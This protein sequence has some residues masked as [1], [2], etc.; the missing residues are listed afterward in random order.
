[1][2]LPNSGG[3]AGARVTLTSA[4]IDQLTSAAELLLSPL[5][6]ESVDAWRSSV[7]RALKALLHADSAGFLLPV[8][9][10]LMLYSDEHDPAEL[11]RY[12]D[13]PPPPLIDGTPLWEQ[14]IKS[15]VI[16]L[17][18]AYGRN[19]GLYTDSVYYQEYAG[20]NGAHDTLAAAVTVGGVDARG[21]ACMHFWHERPDGRLFS[22][23]E[24]ALLRLLYPA[25]KA[26]AETQVAWGTQRNDLLNTL[27]ALGQAVL[28][29]DVASGRPV[30]QTSALSELLAADCEGVRLRAEMIAAANSMRRLLRDKDETRAVVTPAITNL[31]TTSANYT[32]RTTLYGNSNAHTSRVILTAIERR[33]PLVRSEPD[34]Q[35]EFGLTRAESRVAKLIAQGRSNAEIATELSISP[36]TARRH[37]ER[38]LLKLNVRSRTEVPARL[39]R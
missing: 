14:L 20:A 6:H 21:M 15:R 3:V 38:I 31:H 22:E 13:Y 37:T 5:D 27:D 2:A 11:A 29:Y 9:D 17:A 30:H 12:P 25:F 4:D 23:R 35:R 34:L 7:N 32:V 26:G 33:T 1:M 24:V 36:Y 8:A 18:S 10:G 19:Y 28:V 16:T 39:F